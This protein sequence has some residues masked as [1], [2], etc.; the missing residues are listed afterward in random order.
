MLQLIVLTTKSF[1]KIFSRWFCSRY[2]SWF[3][4]A[5]IRDVDQMSIKEIGSALRKTSRLCRDLKIDKKDFLV[6][7]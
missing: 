4:G 2:S 3:N 7:R 5:K 6:V 1:I